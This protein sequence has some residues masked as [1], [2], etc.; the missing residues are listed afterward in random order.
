MAEQVSGSLITRNYTNFRGVDFSNRKDE[1][2]LYR[3]PDS[4]NMW[5]NYKNSKG[6]AIESRPDVELVETYTD[7]IWGLFFYSYGG[8]THKIVHAG[9]KLYDNH[10][11]VYNK[12]VAHKS[13]A[14][15]YDSLLYIKDGANY[16]VYDGKEVKEV[17][18]YIPTTSISRNPSGGGTSYEDTNLLTG[19]RKNSF[20]A[21]G[22]STEYFVTIRRSQGMPISSMAWQI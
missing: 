14:F 21:D 16:L 5:K 11:V 19:V 2:S 20:C 17:E 9:T 1:V 18:G 8:A 13:K 3:S 4:I 10:N 15:I 6:Q 12:M 7:A 22:A